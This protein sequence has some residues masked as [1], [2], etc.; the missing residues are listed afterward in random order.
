M[1]DVLLMHLKSGLYRKDVTSDWPISKK[2][3]FLFERDEKYFKK[4][5]IGA[6]VY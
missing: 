4:C 6:I 2:N 3:W 1:L 5:F